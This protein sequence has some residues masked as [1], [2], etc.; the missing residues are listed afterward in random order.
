MPIQTTS[1]H[2]SQDHSFVQNSFS[3][4]NARKKAKIR[5]LY[6]QVPHLTWLRTSFGKV[7]KT[8]TRKHHIQESQEVS[9]FLTGDPKAARDRHSSIT[10]TNN[11]I[12]PQKKHCLWTVSK[13]ITGGLELVSRYHPHPSFWWGSRH[14]D[15]WFAWSMN[16]LLVQDQCINNM[17][18]ASHAQN[19]HL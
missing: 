10:K 16:H 12:K 3:W 18:A 5:N 6:N 7:T 9:P 15:V 8:T 19:F 2:H 13:K 1:V 17:A 4:D 14:I 11:K